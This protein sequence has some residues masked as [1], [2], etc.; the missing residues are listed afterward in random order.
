MRRHLS[1]VIALVC[2]GVLTA[3]A[4]R[5]HAY[6]LDGTEATGILRL[7]AYDRANRGDNLG[8]LVPLGA[9]L[10][11]DHVTLRLV[12][13]PGFVLPPPD[14]ALSRAIEGMLGGDAS[15][16]GV[17]L[18]D[19]SDP[20]H[21]RYAEVNGGLA[22]NP[23]SVGKLVAALAFFQQLADAHPGDVEAR[24]RV[25]HDTEIVADGFIVD[26]D[27]D[28]PFYR[29]E[30]REVIYR[31]LVEGDTAN[32]WTWFDWMLS[33]SSNAA[34]SVVMKNLLL[35]AHFGAA[36][37]VDAATAENFLANTPKE[38]LSRLLAD[39][40]DGALRRNGLNTGRLRQG[41]FF[42]KAGKAR[43][44][45]GHSIATSRELMQYIVRMEQGRL[46][47][48]F[49]SLEIKRLLYLTEARIRYAA[50]P[51]LADSAV[52]F[53]S[54]SLYS[55][56]P[57]RGYVCDKYVGNRWNFLNSVAIVEGFA[58]APPLDYAVVLLSNVLKKNSAD[59]HRDLAGQI[60]RL[61]VTFY[62]AT[63]QKVEIAPHPSE[64]AASAHQLRSRTASG[65]AAGSEARATTG[66]S[67]MMSSISTIS[68]ASQS[69]PARSSDRATAM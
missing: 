10:R 18:L 7:D 39:T 41:T 30:I 22:Q 55:C 34:A 43:V 66:D 37:P 52:Y 62:G 9:M 6:P 58:Y 24:R 32:L 44:P 38:T 61:I 21:P 53:K 11:T 5:A 3:A 29:E 14:P 40:M 54:G 15:K 23:G 51:E 27:H 35:L 4:E 65:R 20:A 16:Y 67:A 1:T 46:V 42:T 2:A 48:P 68:R 13:Q 64:I 36:Y 19:L 31:P 8:K 56:Q 25:L 60:H 33:A 57:E 59:L 28:V 63:P 45:G 50:A 26:D 17:S 47:D 12:D 69:A 49:S